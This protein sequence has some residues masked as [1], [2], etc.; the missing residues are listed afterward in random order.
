[1]G[2]C[3]G[4]CPA[5]DGVA[6]ARKFLPPPPVLLVVRWQALDDAISGKHTAVDVE[7]SAHH[8]CS[9]GS[10]LLS[11]VFRFIYDLY[12]GL[13]LTTI[14]HNKTTIAAGLGAAV[15][16]LV[17]RVRP[18]SSTT[19]TWGSVSALKPGLML[20]TSSPWALGILAAFLESSAC[21]S[22]I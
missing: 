5:A 13:V 6:G 4:R 15:V 22:Y 3:S 11:Q 2:R 14:D 21:C 17:F 16:T 9:H 20:T 7:V 1:M 18:S 8:E 10:I 19:K 12:I